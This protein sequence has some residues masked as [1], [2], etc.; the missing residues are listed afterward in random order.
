MWDPLLCDQLTPMFK[1]NV[2]GFLTCEPS[3]SRRRRSSNGV[4][5]RAACARIC[6]HDAGGARGASGEDIKTAVIR[7]L[8]SWTNNHRLINLIEVSPA[9]LAATSSHTPRPDPSVRSAY[10]LRRS[11]SPR[12]LLVGRSPYAAPSVA[13]R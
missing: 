5:A 10:L 13:T 11:S 3:L 2:F 9:S 6:P 1:E 8:Q 7:G 12:Y 4:T